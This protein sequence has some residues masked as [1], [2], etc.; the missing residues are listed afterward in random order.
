MG[1]EVGGMTAVVVTMLVEETP[2]MLG[3][4]TVMRVGEMMHLE[5]TMEE[6]L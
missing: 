5:E 3:L 2:A 4:M 6:W 1:T